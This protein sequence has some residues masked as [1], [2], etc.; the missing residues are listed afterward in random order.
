MSVQEDDRRPLSGAQEGLWF[1]QRLAS[2]SAAYNTGEYVEIHGPVDTALFE[3]ALRRTVAEADTFALRFTHTPDGPRCAPDAPADWPLHRVD[4]SGAADPSA[5]A[6]EWIR[7]DLATPVDIE[8]GPLFSHALLTLAPDR[9]IWFLRA[10]HILLDGY[11]YKLVARRLADTYTALAAGE[12]PAPATFEPVG[13]LQE[14]EAAYLASERHARDRAHW[15]ERLAGLPEPVR[16]AERT[17]A[18]VAPFLRRTVDLTPAEAETL[19]AAAARAG[20]SRTDLLVAAVAAYLHRMTGADDLVLGLATMSRLGSAAL[21]TPG[22][23]SDVL[24]LRVRTAAGAPVGELLRTVAAEL[25]DLRRHQQYRGEFLRRDLGL[26]GGGR[27]LHGPVLNIVPFTEDLVFAGHPSTSHHLSGGAVEDLQISV[28]PGADPAGLWLAF[29]ANPAVYDEAELGL[30]LQRFLLLLRQ[31]ADAAPET[32]LADANL[33]LPGEHP[34]DTPASE[35]QV[36]TTLT[37]RFEEQAARAP[38]R[39]AVTCEGVSVSYADLNADANRLARLLVEHGAGPGRMVALALPRGIRLITALLAVL[40][41]GAGYLPLDTRHPEQRLRLVLEDVGP[42]VTVTDDAHAGRLPAVSAPVV[43]LGAPDTDRALAEHGAGD[44]TDADRT[45][46]TGPD[47]I[48]Y[49]IHTSGSTGRP[50]GVPVPHANV[51]RLFEASERHFGFGEDDVWTLFHSYAFDF[52]VWEIWG[53]LL[54]GGRLVVVPYEVSRSP[55]EFLRLLRT[56]GVTVLNQ[57]PSAFE[58]LMRADA[59]DAPESAANGPDAA[60]TADTAGA[61]DAPDGLRLRYVIFGGEALRPERLR[62]WADRHGLDSPVLVNMYGITETTVHVTHHRVT[63]ADLD[64]PRRASVIGR[65]LDDL[66]VHV[67]DAARRPVP[68]GVTGEMYV[69]GPGVAPG[70]LDRPVLTEE[71]FLPDPF[72]RPGSRMYRTGDLARRRADGT[73]EYVGR[74][75]QQVKIRGFRIEPAEIEAELARHSSVA[76]AAVVARRTDGADDSDMQLVAYAVLADG[77][78]AEPAELRAHL[79]AHL[80]EHMVPAACV[81]VEELPLTA[82]GKLDVRALP[83]PDFTAA[84][85]SARPTTPEQRLVCGLF[86]EVLRLPED[87]VGVEDDFFELGGQSLLATRLLARLRAETGTD[88]PISALFDAPRPAALAARLASAPGGGPRT[89]ALTAAERPGRVPLSFAQE[90]MWFLDRLGEASATYNIPL[91]VPLRHAPDE[92][93]LRAALGDLA[94]RHESLRTVFVRDGGATYQRIAPPGELRPVLRVVDCPP[95]ETAAQVAAALRHRFDLTR[96]S[97]LW[98]ALFGTGDERTLLLVLHHSAAD[99]WS[100][101]PLADDL[102]AAYEARRAGRAPRWEPLPVQYADYA[103]WQRRALAP[104]PE[105]PGRLEELTAFWRG[106]LAGLPEESAPPADRPRPHGGTGGGASVT[107]TVDASLHRAL[108]RLADTEGVSMFMVLHAVLGALLSRWGAGEDVVIGTPVAGRTEPVLDDVIGLLTNTVVLR[109]DTSGDPA[110]RDLLARVRAFDVE[111]LDHQDL[112]FDR[113]VE[114]LN[115]PRHPARHPLFQVMLALQNNERAVLR[116]GEDRV[117]LRPTATGT[118]KFDLFVDVLERYGADHAPDGLDLHVEYA[119]DLYEPHTAEEFAQALR[120]LLEAVCADPGVRIGALPASRAARPDADAGSAVRVAEL[121]RTALAVPGVRDAVVLP[122]AGEE[123]PTVYVVA[124]R[125]G[126]VEQVEQA[127]GGSAEA[128]RVNAVSD[129]PRTSDGCL[130]AEALRALPTVDRRAAEAWRRRVA[131][132]P[133]VR[134]ADVRLEDVPREL[135]RR[136]TGAPRAAAV[137]TSGA[138]DAAEARSVSVPALSEGPALPEPSVPDWAS[139]L[140]RA[141]RSPQGEIVHVRADGSETRRSYASLVEE[142]SRVLAGLRRAGL[143]PGDKVILQCGDTE[144]FVA[145]LWGCVLGGFVAVPLTVPASYATASAAV[146]KL[147]GIWRMLGRPWIVASQESEAGL[148]DLAARQEWPGLRLTTA[149]ALRDAPE[150]RDWHPAGPDDL[151]LM[152]MTSGSTG[153]PKAV[154]LTHRNVLT[155]SAATEAMNGLGADDVSLNWIPLDHVTGVVMCHLRDVYLG[156]RQVHAPTPYVLQD[157]LRWADL[158]HRHRA[159][160]TWA[161]N[162]AFGLLA[163]QAHRFHDRDWDLSPMRL[164]MNAGEVVVAATARSFLHALRPFGLPQDVMHPGWGMSETCS[165]VTDC[166]LPSEP[167]GEDESFVSC[168]LPYPGFAMRIVEERDG[169]LTVLA[170]GEVGRLQVRG[171]SVT[172]G[173]HDNAAANAEAFTDDGWFDTGDLAFLREGEL[174]ITGRAKDVIIVNGVNHYSHE[175]EACVEELPGVV[176]SFTAACAVR[177]DPSATTDELALFFHLAP[178]QDPAAVMREIG[179]KVTREIGVSPAFLIP[180]PA[181]AVPKTEIGKIQRTRLRKS[182]EAGEF[183]DAVREA[184]LLLGTAATLPDWFLRPV[185]RPAEALHRTAPPTGQHT[186]VLAGGDP[187]AEELAGRLAGLLRAGG[188]L[189][190]VVTDGPAPERL[191]AARH[192]IRPGSEADHAAL[193]ARLAEDGREID[194]VVHLGALHGPGVAADEADVAPWGER[195]GAESLLVLA[196]ALAERPGR[197]RPVDLLFV[198]AGAQAVAD[199]ERPNPFHA[200]AGALLKSLREEMPWLRGVHLDLAPGDDREAAEA[201][202]AESAVHPVDTEVA[203]RDGR[204]FV[205]RLA[206]LP[207]PLPRTAPPTADGFHLISGGLGGVGSEVAAHLL[208]TPGTRLLLLGRTRLPHEDDWQRHLDEAGPAAGRIEALRRLRRLGE[209]RYESVDVTDA[210]QVRAAVRRAADAWDAPLTSVLHLAGAFDEQPVRDVAPEDWRRLMDAKVRGAWTLHRVAA[211]HPVTSFVVFSSVNGFFGGSMNAAYSAANAFLDALAV[212]RRRAG[213]PGQSLAWSMWRERGMSLGYQ[214]TSLTEARGY[215]VLEASAALRSLD[216]ARTLDEPHLVIGAD[217]TAPWVGS[218]VAAPVR[219]VRRLAGRVGLEEGTDLGAL[220][221]AAAEAAGAGGVADAWVLRSAGTAQQPSA[222]GAGEELR[223][224][225]NELAAVWCTVLGRD[226]VSR[227]ENFFD[228][229]GNSLLLVAAQT[230]LNK[231]LGCELTV[232]DLFAH[233]TVRA[234]ARHLADQGAAVPAASAAPAPDPSATPAG[235]TGA[236]GTAGTA[237][238]D[239]LGRAKE[240]AQRQRAARAARRS[241]RERKDRG[242]G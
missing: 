42:V 152:L 153:L 188:R 223:R 234:L 47:D 89:P 184:Q 54:H 98:A 180:V 226:R 44:L 53:A 123:P 125:A 195:D 237:E 46:P 151:I 211:E 114:E 102:G 241:A 76:H 55:R 68:P 221:A 87:T 233:P 135:E 35:H 138:G 18:P 91:V 70:Y 86:E 63:R 30:H 238:S 26:L 140:T 222:A 40:K 168:G 174:Y 158:A 166:V 77:R 136:H 126:A 8:S 150:D 201:I 90:R 71:R 213:L 192:R 118:A 172:R 85:G 189:C 208:A 116:L 73:L 187:R 154:R 143:R 101:R 182:F 49:V 144:D 97:A 159:T 181:E 14:E 202:L 16:L 82:N 190:T 100:L 232:V 107:A 24:P 51:V 69:S 4:V 95:G 110:F 141:A 41:T 193:L 113:L 94:D 13:R 120:A 185:W 163:E 84:A 227:D 32:P 170:E 11:S 199:D 122:A 157:P 15:A 129:L 115:P 60:D 155:R 167:S 164:V 179:G 165:V 22:T 207:D 236:A 218:H 147:E 39:T 133:G 177:S 12:E 191:D 64:D 93:A 3:T 231:A 235:T 43:V 171:T 148:R 81:L 61:S 183:D 142:A 23:A 186:L 206:P 119:T 149:D 88:V 45:G 228:L 34:E 124:H 99:G 162:F 28:R 178:G 132:V 175:I 29:D 109:T 134:E 75:D 31:L 80:P 52:S 104:A 78:S 66:R 50:K 20:V 205:R 224:L 127:F 210:E 156:C 220:Y 146:A 204:R 6:E 212:H 112:P 9:Y 214:L 229:G 130:D 117:A 65:P 145:V 83:A 74:A 216:F 121:E 103:L 242:R 48:A 58:Q 194:A 240:Q 225:E 56:E 203:L 198:T 128:P 96:D 139:A 230:A 57:T 137:E 197:P 79:A 19:S 105:G 27:R 217:R 33:L 173:Y 67:L 21:R 239:G 25:R 36:T 5:A 169:V 111:A 200:A 196:R 106:A 215:R 160:V 176:R 131:G 37:R 72:G 161:P 1:A 92:E 38:R 2:G 17:A 59:E 7:R 209:V 108:L 219:Q 10:H 62:P